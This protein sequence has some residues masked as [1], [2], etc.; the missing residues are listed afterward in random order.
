MSMTRNSLPIMPSTEI[1]NVEKISLIVAVINVLI[2]LVFFPLIQE[3]RHYLKSVG[4]GISITEFDIKPQIIIYPPV[5]L[6]LS[7]SWNIY[8]SDLVFPW[9]IRGMERTSTAVKVCQER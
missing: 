8:L 4:I 5:S 6:S 2:L 3:R 7:L 9:W 1:T